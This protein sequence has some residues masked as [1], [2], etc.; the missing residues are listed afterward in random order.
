MLF[1]QLPRL[2][3]LFMNTQEMHWIES[4][5]RRWSPK[6]D[7]PAERLEQVKDTFRTPHTLKAALGYY[8]ALPRTPFWRQEN[9]GFEVET[10]ILAG[11]EDRCIDQ[12]MFEAGKRSSTVKQ[13]VIAGAGHFLPME[14]PNEIFLEIEARF[15]GL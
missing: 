13:A 1:Y 7:F 14:K 4:I 9:P 8:R 11:S 15:S 6:W 12:T 5:W 2:P 10:L 3:E